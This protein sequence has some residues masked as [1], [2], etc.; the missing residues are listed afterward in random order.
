MILHIYYFLMSIIT[1]PL[2]DVYSTIQ[3][4]LKKQ[5]RII[6]IKCIYNVIQKQPNCKKKCAAPKNAVVKKDMKSKV[7]AK[8]WL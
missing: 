5:S 6:Q 4:K 3:C 1:L 8:K 7:A 2:G